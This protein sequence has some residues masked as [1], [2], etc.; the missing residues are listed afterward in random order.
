MDIEY[1]REFLELTR[2][3]NYTKTAAKVHITQPTLSKHIVSLEKELGCKLLERDR[4]KVVLTPE[5]NILAAA[6]TEIVESYDSAQARI[7]EVQRSAPI[8]VGGVLHDATISS[9]V[10]IGATFIDQAGLSPVIYHYNDSSSIDDL[11]Q[12]EID[13]SVTN[14]G[15]DEMEEMG[16]RFLPMTRSRFVALVSADNPLAGYSS[17]TMDQLRNARFIKFAD[18]YASSGWR[19]I[20]S[21]CHNHGIVPRTRIVLDHNATNYCTVPLDDNDVMILQANMP[22]LRFLSDF[23]RVAVVPIDDD[24]AAFHLYCIYKAENEERLRPVL[25]AYSRARKIVLSHG[26]NAGGGLLVGKR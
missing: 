5:G 26:M 1:L 4:R 11:I 7:S 8:H 13:I 12:D 21:V 20:E 10:S 3:L 22:Q 25:E 2:C 9:I 23:S 17:I 24:D 18:R 14:C 19:T 16:L 6:A 15:T